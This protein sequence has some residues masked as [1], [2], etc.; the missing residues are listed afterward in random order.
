MFTSLPAGSIE[1]KVDG[2]WVKLTTADLKTDTSAGKAFTQAD[3]DAHNVRYTPADNES[4]DNS[5]GGTGVGN[6]QGD[7]TELNFQATDGSSYSDTKTITVDIHPVTDVPVLTF[8]QVPTGLVIQ[9]WTGSNLP[10][11]LG[12]NGQGVTQS[13]TLIN[14]INA[15]TADSAASTGVTSNVSNG[16]VAEGTA[17]KVSGLVYLEAGKSY[18]FSGTADDS[19][20][21][22][23]GGKLVASETWSQGSGIGGSS[24]TPT[25]SGYYTLDIYHYNQ[26]GPGNYDVNVSTNNGPAVS[27]G[28]SGLQTYTSVAALEAAGMVLGDSH[29][30]NGE[31]YYTGSVYNHGLEDT[32]IK[33]APITATFVDND[34]SESHKVEIS[35]LPEGTVLTDGTTG[36]SITSTGASTLYDVSTWN[37][38]TLTVTP[39]KDSTASFELTVKATA[40][41]LSTGVEEVTSGKIG[42]V[43]TAVN[44]APVLGNGSTNAFGDTYIEGK[45]GGYV[46]AN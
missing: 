32:A 1:Y 41:E 25:E 9:T 6:K 28:N 34:G 22:T 35:G 26:N 33:I 37:L 45:P 29:V 10:A 30:V 46:A 39:F 38:S 17:T 27:L 15:Q 4:G 24:Y 13:S 21:I 42:I 7:Y 31:G 14:V 23:V 18:T 20:A 12:T 19:L 44:D 8:G 36:H 2:E 11:E 5:F 3:F 40:K 16:N 43:V